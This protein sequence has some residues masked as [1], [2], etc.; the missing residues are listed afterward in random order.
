[1]KI[2]F[3]LI[4]SIFLGTLFLFSSCEEDERTYKSVGDDMVYGTDNKIVFSKTSESIEILDVTDDNEPYG[5]IQVPIYIKVLGQAP[6]SDLT[7]N[8]NIIEDSTTAV[9]GT[10][11][12]LSDDKFVIPANSTSGE[13]VI[14]V[15]NDNMPMADTAV[16]GEVF[17][18][19]LELL[20]DNLYSDYTTM[21]I[22]MYK[23]RNCILL[24]EQFDG[25]FEVDVDGDVRDVTI[26]NDPNVENGIII[27]DIWVGGDQIK[28][29]IDF[30]M[31]ALIPEAET[32]TV[33]DGDFGG[34]GRIDFEDINGGK[35]TDKCFT[36]FEFKATPTLPETGY[37][38]GG[39]FTFKFSPK[40]G[41]K[42]S[43][44]RMY[45]EVIRR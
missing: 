12:S 13:L 29:T 28:F 31:L 4:T 45:P 18:L 39:E 10:H 16:I 38:W 32:V 30:E 44:E 8:F 25:T 35:V 24:M 2:K 17:N 43:A 27:Y 14:T 7:V 41:N 40:K 21:S 26:E 19:E 20:G 37:W 34:Y 22:E 1:M 9:E 3:K 11:F 23:K 42:A 5:D 15:H 33:Y 6:T 36:F